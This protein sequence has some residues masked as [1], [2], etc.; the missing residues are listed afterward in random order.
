MVK[1]SRAMSL[2]SRTLISKMPM[3]AII[4]NRIKLWSLPLSHAFALLLLAIALC[5]STPVLASDL[6]ATVDRDKIGI[7]E[8]VNLR[9]RYSGDKSGGQPDFDLLEQ[10]FDILSRQQSN[11]YRVING[12]AESFVEWVL[13][14]APKREG[15]LFIPSF[16]YQGEVSDAVPVTVTEAQSGPNG[17]EKQAFL[18]V[19]LD[20]EK[21]YVQEQLLVKIR[22]YTTIGLHDIAT[23]PLK[24][25]GAHAEKVDEQR[26]ERK[27]NDVSHAVYE[28]TYAVF[29]DSSGKLSIPALTYVAIAGRRDPFSLF[30]RNSQR[31]RLRSQEKSIEVLPKPADHSGSQW[32]PAASLGI[33]Q[34]W[35][36]DPDTFAVGE[37]ITRIL[38]V[39]AEG[40]R[41]AQLP[42]LPKLNVD[43]L[44]TYPDQPQQEDQ[45][46]PNG[47]T[48]S[49]I[50]TTAIVATQPGD[51]ELPPVTVTW[52]DT[53]SQRQRTT[54]L[55][56]FRFSVSG[57]AAAVTS[58]NETSAKVPQSATPTEQVGT[59]SHFWRNLAIIAIASH[60]LWVLYF[61]FQRRKPAQQIPSNH[62]QAPD[63]QRETRALKKALESENPIHMQQATLKWLAAK[64]PQVNG[65]SLAE[66]ARQ[67]HIPELGQLQAVLDAAIYK[68]P[69]SPLDINKVKAIVDLLLNAKPESEPREADS[70]LPSLFS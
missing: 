11:Q 33:V 44:K 22:L 15:K 1:N 48:G 25:A 34:S 40:L 7:D 62:T 70:A 16:N 10:D 42:P 32:L 56:A 67:L 8:T 28:V 65:K 64:W 20:K 55:P 5:L 43:G 3:D 49:R 26:Y 35:S 66:T 24:V 4:N 60:L 19:T 68:S 14:L 13:A 69:A 50:E 53:K 27:L 54:Q 57:T 61:F 41:A 21:V 31:L 37:P 63:L 47:V 51:Y 29:P 12:R 36:Q 6:S 18:E 52:W 46:G 30:N 17:G 9:V 38:T 45:V 59:V 39:R 58:D 2:D 23:E